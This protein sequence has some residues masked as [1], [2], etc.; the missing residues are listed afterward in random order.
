ML[1]KTYQPNYALC[2]EMQNKMVL[3]TLVERDDRV[4][5]V[6]FNF[7]IAIFRYKMEVLTS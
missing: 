1:Y 5:M 3:G 4:H 2:L 6:V 7:V